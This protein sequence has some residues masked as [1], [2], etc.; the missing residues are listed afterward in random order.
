MK[1]LTFVG[2]NPYEETCYCWECHTH[3]SAFLAEALA[4]WLQP[5]RILVLL[6][7]KASQ[8]QNWQT[9]RERLSPY[10][11]VEVPIADGNNEEEVWEIFHQVV[12]A[13]D[14][15]DRLVLDVTHAFRS[16]PMLLLVVSA[17]LRVTKNVQIEHIFYGQYVKG[18]EPT[19][20]LDLLPLLQLL[21]WASATQRFRET[22]DARWIGE[23]LRQTHRRLWKDRAATPQNLFTA[24]VGLQQ[25]SL[26]LQLARPRETTQTAHHL[27]TSL[28]NAAEEI[29]T[30]AR[31]FSLLLEEVQAQ[32]SQMAYEHSDTLDEVHLRK[33]LNF[34]RRLCDYGMVMQSALMAREWVV[35]WALWYKNGG[36]SLQREQWLDNAQ[37]D[38]MESELHTAFPPSSSPPK[39]PDWLDNASLTQLL[40]VLWPGLCT[41]RNDLA[42]C[43]MRPDRLSADDAI[44]QTREYLQQLEEL[45]A[46]SA[47][48]FFDQ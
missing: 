26:A 6:T 30:W 11:L 29:A 34:I 35:N 39:P 40:R 18:Q 37:R 13:V 20:V 42:H 46:H 28:R 7:S 36:V 8:H 38:R 10:P 9:L 32:A 27:L 45:L 16:L 47:N 43:G 2:V 23:T 21:D 12:S 22:G 25:L 41:L 4:H 33:Q 5:E 1:L 15:G 3:R 44:R 48:A 31:P 14:E 24:G 19:P 17:F